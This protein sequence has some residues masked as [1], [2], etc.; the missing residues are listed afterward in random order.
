MFLD[1]AFSEREFRQILP[2]EF[3]PVDHF[4]ATHVKQI[5]RQH[6]VL[7]VIAEHVGVIAFCRSHPLSFLQ[8]LDGRN[9]ITIACCALIFLDRRR[10]LHTR[11]QRTSQIRRTPFQKHF[12]VAHSFLIGLRSGQI[13]NAGSQTAFDVVL[14]TRARVKSC[15][16]HLARGDQKM[17]VDQVR[18][19]IRK[20]RG[21]VWA[22][23]LAAI[24]AQPPRHIHPRPALAQGQLHIGIGLVVAQ[25]D[26]EPRLALFDEVVLQRQSLFVVGNNDVIDID[27]L[28]HQSPGLGVL[29]S[30]L[31]K[32]AGN[33]AAEILGLPHVDDLTLG[34]LVQIHAGFGGNGLDFFL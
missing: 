28:A 31:M 29:P 17:P 23:V 5:H 6:A 19:A 8:L 11:T 12:H 30:S 2:E 13:L 26:V 4:P 15:Q 24:F 18:D 25:Q 21:K 1:V 27:G 33:P 9:Q 34:V 16:V 32:V 22:I 20:I 14:Q 10:L 3:P 7:V